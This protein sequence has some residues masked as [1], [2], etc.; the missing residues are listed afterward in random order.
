MAFNPESIPSAPQPERKHSVPFKWDKVRVGREVYSLSPQE[1]TTESILDVGRVVGPEGFVGE[2]GSETGR[3]YEHDIAGS[4]GPLPFLKLSS[5]AT[6]TFQEAFGSIENQKRSGQ[7]L[8]PNIFEATAQQIIE[9]FDTFS[10]QKRKQ[11]RT[12]FLNDLEGVLEDVLK[13]VSETWEARVYPSSESPMDSFGVDFFVD[14]YQD[15]AKQRRRIH[16][17]L[18]QNPNKN[19]ARGFAHL[20]LAGI[21]VGDKSDVAYRVQ[22][23]IIAQRIVRDAIDGSIGTHFDTVEYPAPFEHR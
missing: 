4:I 8:N 9:C 22:L 17:D 15:N 5:G 3:E 16:F 23:R 7:Y 6:L 1:D 14:V 13:S 10:E 21:N 11:I 12:Q 18:T 20:I 2:K 19:V